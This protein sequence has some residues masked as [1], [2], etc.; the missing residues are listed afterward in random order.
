MKSLHT[1]YS[2]GLKFSRSFKAMAWSV[3]VSLIFVASVT[4]QL[5]PSHEDK[6]GT[7]SNQE[8]LLKKVMTD[9]PRY[10]E[11]PAPVA[12]PKPIEEVTSETVHLVPLVVVGDK[13]SKLR[14]FQLL[15]KQAFASEI[16]KNYDYSAFSM[17]QHRED[18]R[19][20]D[21]TTLKNYADNLMLVGDVEGS[22]AI[23]KENSRLFLRSR[24]PESEYVDA[25]F[26]PRVR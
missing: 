6:T 15:T 8:P 20:M 18:V 23:R 25:L 12:N 24:D 9:M 3:A 1:L 26:N 10:G 13:R 21:M 22:R 17:F 5:A 2:P 4:G 11:N 19:L 14:G 7:A 16:L